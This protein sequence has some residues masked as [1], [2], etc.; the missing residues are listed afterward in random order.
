MPA[1]SVS[2]EPHLVTQDVF[3]S[4]A[5]AM[6][7]T[8]HGRRWDVLFGGCY[9]AFSDAATAREALIDVHRASVNNALYLN[10]PGV[11][12]TCGPAPTLPPA[13]VLAQYPDVLEKFPELGLSLA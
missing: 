10:L 2:V 6:P 8:N 12:A 3:L 4:Q 13:E 11:V 1:A 5:R 7:L 9:S